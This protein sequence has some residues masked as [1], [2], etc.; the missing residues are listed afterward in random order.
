MQNHVFKFDLGIRNLFVDF[1]L[2]S[3]IN[4]KH[5]SRVESTESFRMC[6]L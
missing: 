3:Y 4:Y 2:S 1:S 6:L 5:I